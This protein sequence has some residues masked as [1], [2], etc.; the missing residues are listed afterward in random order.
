MKRMKK[1]YCYLALWIV[2]AFLFAWWV[3][4]TLWKMDG[5]GL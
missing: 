4:P 3:L 1:R 5:Y 2:L